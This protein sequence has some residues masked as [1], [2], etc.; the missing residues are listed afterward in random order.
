MYFKASTTIGQKVFCYFAF[1]KQRY[2]LLITLLTLS[3]LAAAHEFWLQPAFF[4]ATP[5]STV[6]VDI[7]VGEGFVGEASEGKKNR[8]V[9]YRHYSS[10]D[11]TSLTPKLVGNNYGSVSIKFT[12]PGT[13]LLVFANTPKFITLKPKEFLA[14]L[15]EDGLDHV[16]AA[17]QQLGQTNK[18]S[19]ELYRRCVKSLV[20]VGDQP[21]DTYARPTNLTLDITPTQNPYTLRQGQMAGFRV[22][23]RGKPLA[24]ALVRHWVSPNATTKATEVQQRSD[25][26]GLVQFKLLSG[27]NMVSTVLMIPNDEDTK[28]QADWQSYWGSLTFGVSREGR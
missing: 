4:F 17:R 16:V 24:D 20:Q 22:L 9:T 18:P 13:H 19:R 10:T 14:Y 3:V 26:N 6:P 8:I 23:F 2:L 1:M 7:L 12:Q 15:K 28:D 5:G 21:D 11:S 25:A 27:R